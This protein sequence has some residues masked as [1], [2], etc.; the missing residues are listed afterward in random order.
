[1]W[2]GLTES[3]SGR[4][5]RHRR[6]VENRL[7]VGEPAFGLRDAFGDDDEEPRRESLNESGK[8]HRVAGAGKTT[9]R[10][11]LTGRRNGV[12]DTGERRQR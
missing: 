10:Q 11:A 4:V 12:Q 6:L 3:F 5:Q 1:V 2:F 7:Q 9:D 8:R